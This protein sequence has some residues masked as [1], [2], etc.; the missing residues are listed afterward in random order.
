MSESQTPDA[1]MVMVPRDEMSDDN[2]IA[3]AEAHGAVVE[4]AHEPDHYHHTISFTPPELRAM[5]AATQQSPD[6]T[7]VILATAH[8]MAHRMG[9]TFVEDAEKIASFRAGSEVRQSPI[10]G[11]GATGARAVIRD[12]QI[13]ISI[14]V[15]ALPVIVSGS[16]ASMGTMQGLWKVTDAEAFAKDV[17]VSL[18]NEQEDGTTRVHLMFDSAFMH[19]IEQGAEGIDEVS[20]DEF[21]AECGRLHAVPPVPSVSGGEDQ[22]SNRQGD[23]PT[24]QV[25]GAVVDHS[26]YLSAVAGRMAFRDAF[27]RCLPVVRAAD[28]LAAKWTHEGQK[29]DSD[30][31]YAA[32]HD[33]CEAAIK[34]NSDHEAEDRALASVSGEGGR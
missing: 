9:E 23:L 26:V 28:A 27:R 22:G 11:E 1:A 25:G 14:D 7:D 29:V 34:R 16:C 2:L 20:E 33:V 10:S 32:I 21:E 5:I 13:V 8:K 30:D 24:E 18:N 3:L 19:A 31:F 15:D 17:C 6:E 12:G 4:R